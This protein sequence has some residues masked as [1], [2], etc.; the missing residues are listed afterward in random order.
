M[1]LSAFTTGFVLCASLVISGCK[2]SGIVN[3]IVS[4]EGNEVEATVKKTVKI[5]DFSE[6][7]ASQGIKIIYKQGPNKHV[8]DIAT[9]PS[10][11]KYLKVEVNNNTLKAY[12]SN[13]ED[14]RNVKIK[15]PTTIYVSS[16]ELN[17]IDLSSAA[18]LSIDGTLK[19]NGNLE[20]DLSSASSLDAETVNCR[21]LDVDLSSSAKVYIGKLIGNLDA[22]ISSASSISVNTMEGILDTE[23]SSAAS[24]SIKSIKTS[25]ISVAASSAS[26]VSLDGILGGKISASA[27]SGAKIKLSGNAEYLK[28]NTSSG[29]SVNSSKLSVK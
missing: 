29:G 24:L 9:T 17:E 15:G 4:L 28:H 26:S 22:D 10:A 25:N 18:H 16:P 12:Y 1:N 8:A 21:N 20:I 2:A 7:E 14:S 6:I 5:S 13:N 19:V 3:S 11:E 27:T 23:S